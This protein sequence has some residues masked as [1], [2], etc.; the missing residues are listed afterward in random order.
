[1]KDTVTI[2]DVPFS[3]YSLEQTVEV[4]MQTVQKEMSKP[5]HLITG[6]PEIVLKHQEDA[7]LRQIIAEADFITPDGVGIL[8]AAKWQGSPLPER[9]TGVDLLINLLEAGNHTGLS[10]YFLGA[11]EETSKLAVD[12]ISKEYPNVKIA[13]R[14]HGY[15]NENEEEIILTHI[16]QTRPDIVIVALGAPLAEKWI[17]NHRDRLKTKVTFGVGGSLDIIAGTVKRAP[18]LWQKLNIEW[19]HRLLSQPSRW[20]RQLVLPV[21]AYRAYTSRKR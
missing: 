18:M 6:N 4:L 21:F 16:E 14:H 12:N 8:L 15:F 7:E 3:T 17:Y 13:G 5:F 20:R 10:F 11:K 1:M 9:V 2:L 19:L